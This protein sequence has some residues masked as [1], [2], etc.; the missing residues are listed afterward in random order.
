LQWAFSH[1]ESGIIS[2]LGGSN[3]K[4]L[5]FKGFHICF[6]VMLFFWACT[7]SPNF[8]QAD[9]KKAQEDSAYFVSKA[10]GDTIYTGKPF[11]VEGALRDT[12]LY[13]LNQVHKGD[14]SYHIA[15]IP[16]YE[17]NLESIVRVSPVYYDSMLVIIPGS[18]TLLPFEDNP[19]T[20]IN[21]KLKSSLNINI[22]ELRH[23]ENARF[24]L[25]YLDAQAGLVSSYVNTIIFDQNGTMWIGSTKGLSK[26]DGRILSHY[27]GEDGLP[28]DEI[29]VLFEDSNGILWI[30]TQYGGIGKY[31]GKTIQIYNKEN[32]LP[33]NSISGFTEDLSGNIWAGIWGGGV[34]RFKDHS[35]AVLERMHG[36]SEMRITDV[37]T[38]EHGNIWIATNGKGLY[39]FDGKE[40]KH[41]SKKFGFGTNY[42]LKIT[43]DSQNRMWMGNW[44]NLAYIKGDSAYQISNI[45]KYYPGIP[46]NTIYEDG[47]QN[48]WFVSSTS[49]VSRWDGTI[50]TKFTEEDGLPTNVATDMAEDPSGNIW[51]S[52]SGGGITRYN[53]NSFQYFDESAG[54]PDKIVHTIIETKAGLVTMATSAGVVFLN[55]TSVNR[56]FVRDQVT[57]FGGTVYDIYETRDSSLWFSQ[58]NGAVYRIKNQF[59][60]HI[61]NHQGMH[62]HNITAITER[63]NGE[64]W[65]GAWNVGLSRMDT[66]GHFTVFNAKVGLENFV[67]TD[68]IVDKKDK[69]WIGTDGEGVTVYDGEFFK[70]IT[71]NEG[72]KS[73][74]IN[75]LFQ[76]Q[77]EN[78]WVLSK[79][80]INRISQGKVE[81]FEFA[82]LLPD[83]NVVSMVEDQQQNIWVMT[84][85]GILYLQRNENSAS[86]VW[87]HTHYTPKIF[88]RFDGLISTDFIPRSAFVDSKNRI[89]LGTGRG[90]MMKNL[91]EFDL[92]PN[93]PNARIETI[94]INGNFIDYNHLDD[95]LYDSLFENVDKIKTGISAPNPFENYPQTLTLPA[96]CNHLT[97]VFSTTGWYTDKTF[98]TYRLVGAD[99]AWCNPTTENWAEYRNLGYGEY[100]FELKTIGE[101]GIESDVLKYGFEILPPW[102]HTWWARLFYALIIFAFVRFVVRLRTKQLRKKQLELEQKVQ[103]RTAELDLKNNELVS[104]N[105]I[106]EEQKV[107]V[108]KR[109]EEIERQHTLLE[110]THKEIKDS[111]NYAKRIQEAI[112]PTP[113][114]VTSLIPNNFILY[115]PK[116]VVAGDFYWIEA[117]Q[118]LVLF[119]AA[120]CTGHGVPGA[121]VS[122]VCHNAFNRAV[123]EFNESSPER[124]LNKTREIVLETFQQNSAQVNDGMDASLISLRKMNQEGE[125][126]LL[127]S[128]A[129]NSVSIVRH[130]E[131]IEL[132]G[133]KQPVGNYMEAKPFTLKSFTLKKGDLVYLFTDGYA[134]QF[135]GPKGKKLK[136][137]AL[138]ELLLTHADLSLEDQK[139]QLLHYLETWKGDLEQLDDISVFGF[140]I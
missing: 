40:L 63:A 128:G 89:W 66:K 61:G 109:K 39:I 37:E 13:F 117:Y 111:I 78:I 5:S 113:E 131:M 25:Q 26:Y 31:D 101:S 30:G 118:D 59:I 70:H 100:T 106:I 12:S 86:E 120:D 105:A 27:T 60:K 18:D 102:Y 4:N 53:P 97:F 43:R 64:M 92:T 22:G 114:H 52:L 74:H 38:D 94:K 2:I 112:L 72:L 69:L 44:D 121:M 14:A 80:G 129:N 57:P 124:I 133:D 108:E 42:L 104:Q 99:D 17:S 8:T 55:D 54:L 93:K 85:D 130:G 48:I 11:K 116:D 132:E 56:I 6:C 87:N 126:E 29:T 81:N 127:F 68:L 34:V 139:N 77:D 1:F 110:E 19:I 91:T 137:K 96:N 76:D 65:F 50:L 49:G 84:S 123:R 136:S 122:V 125:V 90:V 83:Q 10:T 62:D 119:S 15:E 20:S 79:K 58:L 3:L 82:H 67:I 23:K 107:E 32:G 88:S 35:I 33:A 103:E 45:D 36:L 24:D 75:S 98:F 138:K 9:E 134:D 41:H 7:E 46:S 140:K 95:P 73:N 16:R 28:D 135:G 115:Q 71:V 21:R 47:Q 51:I